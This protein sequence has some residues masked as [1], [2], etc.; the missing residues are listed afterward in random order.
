MAHPFRIVAWAPA[1]LALAGWGLASAATLES[2]PTTVVLSAATGAGLMYV[3]NRGDRPV[4]FQAEAFDWSQPA[5]TDVLTPS[6]ALQISPPIAEIAPGATQI[7]RLRSS[8]PAEP[9]EQSFRVVVSE[10][11]RE[12]A[13]Q[14]VRI[15]LQ[16]NMPVFRPT[17]DPA[18]ARL[19][20][21]ASVAGRR[22]TLFAENASGKHVKLTDLSLGRG[23][24]R[25]ELATLAY[26]LPGSVRSWRA[27]GVSVPAGGT[28]NVRY[29]DRDDGPP[30]DVAVRVEP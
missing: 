28:V 19:T 9:V 5:G 8:G 1:L 20:W 12:A 14:E 7:V 26:V 3:S 29:R 18:P 24:G 15:L 6:R 13:G 25:A 30:V 23:G 4:A 11:P 22:L 17:A 2:A 27:D 10:L 21:T 16:F